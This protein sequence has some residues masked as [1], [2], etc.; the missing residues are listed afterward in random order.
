MK[1][2]MI[3]PAESYFPVKEK[4]RRLR[5]NAWAVKESSHSVDRDVA[6]CYSCIVPNEF[7][8]MSCKSKECTY[9]FLFGVLGTSPLHGFFQSLA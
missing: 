8:V 4:I 9:F 2:I 5:R 3:N 6:C 7:P 1:K